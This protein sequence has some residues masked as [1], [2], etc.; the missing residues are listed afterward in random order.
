MTYV[1]AKSRVVTRKNL[2]EE[3]RSVK[4][5]GMR[6]PPRVIASQSVRVIFPVRPKGSTNFQTTRPEETSDDTPPRHARFTTGFMPHLRSRLQIA[7]RPQRFGRRLSTEEVKRMADETKVG[8]Q[9][10][11][12]GIWK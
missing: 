5:A 8:N 6:N 9:W 2:R 10:R 3:G 7:D 1:P 12:S 11:A 4:Q